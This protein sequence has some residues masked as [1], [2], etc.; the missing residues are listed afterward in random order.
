MSF[1]VEPLPPFVLMRGDVWLADLDPIVGH[2]LEKCRPAVIV[3][4]DRWNV[5]PRNCMVVVVP[6]K[7]WRPWKRVFR[8]QVVLEGGQGGLRHTSLADAMHV[9]A[10]DRCRLVERLG[11]LRND[12]MIAIDERLSA[13][14]AL[15]LRSTRESQVG[16]ESRLILSTG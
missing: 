14:L 10:I 2:E 6:I 9:R 3:S 11:F 4:D 15:P 8:A 12:V 7:S 16:S 1:Q 13:V 5:N